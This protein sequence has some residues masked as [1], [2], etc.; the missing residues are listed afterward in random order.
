MN[1]LIN[2]ELINQKPFVVLSNAANIPT[3]L[4]FLLGFGRGKKVKEGDLP[5]GPVVKTSPFNAGCEGS[6]P[7]WGTK[8]PHASWTK[9][10]YI[11]QKQYCNKFNKDFKNG[12]HQ[13]YL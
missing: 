9:N 10:K 11:K 2:G 1:Y 4:S 13:E 7:G 3:Y 6:F 12:P 5:G 8:I